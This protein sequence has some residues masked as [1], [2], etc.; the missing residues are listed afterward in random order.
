MLGTFGAAGGEFV[1]NGAGAVVETDGEDAGGDEGEGGGNVGGDPEA[2]GLT[3]VVKFDD[4]A[5]PQN[6]GGGLL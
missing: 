3:K 5:D 4:A 2:G 6:S 1:A